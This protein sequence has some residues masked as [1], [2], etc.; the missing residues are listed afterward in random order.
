MFTTAVIHVS[1]RS[2]SGYREMRWWGRGDGDVLRVASALLC[3]IGRCGLVCATPT[4]TCERRV[5]HEGGG[6]GEGALD[7]CY[8]RHTK[9]VGVRGYWVVLCYRL[10][11][12]GTALDPTIQGSRN[13][14]HAIPYM[15]NHR[16]S[17]LGKDVANHR[18][19][20]CKRPATP[21]HL[22]TV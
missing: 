19:I 8:D 4:L 22:A 6:G 20:H 10:N 18:Q 11:P 14:H 13:R 17:T 12:C 5:A 3:P 7:C 1:A 9:G 21:A 15:G 2:R 16:S